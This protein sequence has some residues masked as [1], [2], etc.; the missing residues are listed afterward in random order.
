MPYVRSSLWANTVARFYQAG[1]ERCQVA[2][3]RPVDESRK[4]ATSA[5][6]PEPV[7]VGVAVD[8]EALC[9]SFAQLSAGAAGVGVEGAE[10]VPTCPNL[11][12]Q[13]LLGVHTPPVSSVQG[14]LR[15]I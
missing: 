1:F 4:A 3:R 7:A 14:H 13:L 9:P 8:N 2:Q 11:S 12:Q 5:A 10:R 15:I 6:L